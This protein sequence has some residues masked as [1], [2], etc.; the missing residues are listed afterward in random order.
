MPGWYPAS[1]HEAGLHIAGGWIFVY[2]G[3]CESEQKTADCMVD[4][5][6]ALPES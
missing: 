2:N 3:N 1:C 4:A 6:C 5:D